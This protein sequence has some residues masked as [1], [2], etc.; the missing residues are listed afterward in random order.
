M[1]AVKIIWAKGRCHCTHVALYLGSNLCSIC[2]AL[3]RSS[4]KFFLLWHDLATAWI[5][6]SQM[7]QKLLNLSYLWPDAHVNNVCIWATQ[8]NPLCGQLR[9]ITAFRLWSISSKSWWE[10]LFSLP[11]FPHWI[12]EASSVCLKC[13]HITWCLELV[14]I[15]FSIYYGSCASLF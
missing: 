9:K 10:L 15:I 2:T 7:M 12:K 11:N 3:L 5:A 14:G 4:G 13:G 8:L 1:G 6:N